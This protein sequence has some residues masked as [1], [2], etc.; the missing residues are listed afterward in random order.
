MVWDIEENKENCE[1]NWEENY[2]I[3][4]SDE[5]E[6]DDMKLQLIRGCSAPFPPPLYNTLFLLYDTC[7]SLLAFYQIFGFWRINR[8]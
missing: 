7:F 5:L 2:S 3:G 8:E 4:G 6:K 1:E